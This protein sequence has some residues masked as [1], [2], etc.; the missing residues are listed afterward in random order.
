MRELQ[1]A[2]FVLGAASLIASATGLG[3]D[4]GA[5]F[6]K[7]GIALLLLDVVCIQL[8]PAPRRP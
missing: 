1:I 4:H 6:L 3:S 2:L 5:M 7:T 8:W